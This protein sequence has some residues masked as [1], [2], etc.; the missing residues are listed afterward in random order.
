MKFALALCTSFLVIPCFAT[1][2]P[3]PINTLTT[4][5]SGYQNESAQVEN[6]VKQL[7]KI[8][9][10]RG[11]AKNIILF[12]GDGMGVSTVT[13]A[14]ILEGQLR[15]ESGE[16]NLLSFEHFPFTGLSKTYNIDAQTP[17]SA[18][19]MTALVTGAKTNAG[20]L[21]LDERAQRSNCLS[22]KH[23]ELTTILELAEL[24]QKSTGI[25]ST[26]RITH[27]TPAATF[28]KSPDR[29]WEDDTSMGMDAKAQ[30]CRDIALQ[31]LEFKNSMYKTFAT[32]VD[33]IDVALGGGWRHF[34]PVQKGGRR[35]DG[36]DLIAEW[37]S[38]Y[39]KSQYVNSRDELLSI[40]FN[41]KQ[42]LLG[43]FNPSHLKYEEE[44]KSQAKPTEPSLSEM[45]AAALKILKKNENGYFLMVEAGRIDHSHHAGNAYNALHDTI[46]MAKAVKIALENSSKKDTLIIVTADHSHVFTIAG[47]P[48]RGNPILGKVVQPGKTKPET[49]EDG[50]EYTT[51][52]YMNGRGFAYFENN[53]NADA[54]YQAPT[55][56][57]RVNLSKIDTEHAG[58]HQEALVPLSA[59]TH[60]GE[61]VAI[62]ASGPGAALVS[63]VLEQNRIFHI[64][65]YAA[66]LT[67]KAQQ[68]LSHDK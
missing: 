55:R 14:R 41:K 3:K 67:T 35:S 46:E 21:S 44:R 2:K 42:K 28:A 20:I 34:L 33:G 15:G 60:G 27:A 17:D 4:K 12:V 38:Q 11:A 68:A 58:F 57:G 37:K 48:R 65:N 50:L 1:E 52:G 22:A 13:A 43:L 10:T 31:F 36:R 29:N 6:A 51:L 26:A 30:G 24:A 25:V 23:T 64:M 66:D 53:K 39:P 7:Q 32:E 18:G 49:A 9:L 54:R 47:Y 45:T 8:Q 61:D 62:Y 63:G 5:V 59:E 56:T 19:T 40:D 16:E